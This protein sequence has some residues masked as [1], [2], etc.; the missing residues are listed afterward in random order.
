[1]SSR[2]RARSCPRSPPRRRVVPQVAVGEQSRTRLSNEPRRVCTI[3]RRAP[4]CVAVAGGLDGFDSMSVSDPSRAPSRITGWSRPPSS[5]LT[6]TDVTRSGQ[7]R[8]GREL[9]QPEELLDGGAVALQRRQVL[10]ADRGPQRDLD[11]T[12]AQPPAGHA[13]PLHDRELAEHAAVDDHLAGRRRAAPRGSA[14]RAAS[15]RTCPAAAAA[16][17]APAGGAPTGARPARRPAAPARPRSPADR[18]AR[19][20]AAGRPSGPGRGRRPAHGRPG[21]AGRARPGRRSRSRRRAAG[22]Q[23]RART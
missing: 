1:M 23:S 4:G 13:A 19:R 20:A 22:S 15:A 17:A 3:A 12:V 5:P 8:P 6:P 7:R 9:R 18:R 14:S 21:S 11:P 16:A 10:V 2:S